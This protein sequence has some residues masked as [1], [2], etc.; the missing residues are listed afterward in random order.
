[1][2]M[3]LS[4]ISSLTLI[5][6]L[7]GCA[8]CGRSLEPDPKTQPAAPA[9]GFLQMTSFSDGVGQACMVYVPR[10]YDPSKQWPLIVVLHGMGDRGNDGL[11]VMRFGIPQEIIRFP[12][13]FPALVV[14]PQC[15]SDSV[16]SEGDMKWEVEFKDASGH[17][18]SAIEQMLAKYAID[19]DRI[20]L[21]GISMGGFGTFVY[22]AKNIERFSA[23]LPI[24]GGGRIED[25]ERLAKRPIRVFHGAD[26]TIV[27]PEQSTRMVEAIRDAGGDIEYTEF[28]KTGHV[29]WKKAYADEKN[30]KWLIDQR[31]P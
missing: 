12:H 17:I 6:A 9:T 15:P 24:C 29:S 20:S 31:R 27:P 14:M 25:A 8:S 30:I 16:W 23:L 22:G 4:L 18:D 26:D 19:E 5:L 28:P 10:E 3:K 13:R 11:R 1:M 2:N 7:A 21:T